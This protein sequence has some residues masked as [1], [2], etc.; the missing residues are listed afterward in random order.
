MS[1]AGRARLKLLLAAAVVAVVAI[2]VV[3]GLHWWRHVTVTS[4]WIDA[5]FT[6]MGSGV[7]GRIKRI[8]VRKGDTVRQGDLLATMDSELAELDAVAIQADLAKA[9]AERLRI[10]AE[11]AAFRRDVKDRTESL[12]TVLVLQA[13]EADALKRRLAIAEKTVDR[14]A[15]LIKRQTISRQTDDAARDRLLEVLADIREVE[16]S[17]AEK[18]RKIAE[19]AGAEVEEAIFVSRLQVID[20][21][22]DKL[23][24]RL[25]RAERQLAKMHI[26][27]PIDAVVNEIFENAGAYVEDGDRVFLLHDPAALWI[28]APVDEADIRHV[29]VGQDV[30]IDVDAY[31]YDTFYGKVRAVGQ[32]TVSAINGGDGGERAAPSVPVIVDIDASDYVLWPGARATVNIRTR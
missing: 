18:R 30:E 28:E 3:E 8:E 13:R 31:P 1:V 11:L 7:N 16:T 27:A 10:E 17:M 24:V 9:R 29:T 21:E 25:R 20:R 15:K 6:V 19:M 12:K 22:I 5:D 14:N 26:Y 23:G 2:G 32:V 4:A